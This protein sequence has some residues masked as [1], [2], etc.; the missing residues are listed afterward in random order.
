MK[1]SRWIILIVAAIAV[2]AL[3]IILIPKSGDT[4]PMPTDETTVYEKASDETSPSTSAPTASEE[5]NVPSQESETAESI[6]PENG[7]D[8][9][10]ED[11][12]PGIEEYV[13]EL[14]DDESFV[15]N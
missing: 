13:V 11:E 3:V 2:V 10:E 12:D 4:K 7:E 14:S 5:S 8:D 1:R 6:P 15:I 9:P